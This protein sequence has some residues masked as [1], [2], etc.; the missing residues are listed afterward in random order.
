MPEPFKNLFNPGMIAEMGAHLQRHDA[1][2]DGGRFER[3]ATHGLDALELK[4]RSNHILNA[5]D[6]TLPDDF[7]AAVRLMLTA[8][9][10]EEH[11]DLSEQSMDARGIRG[12]A[13]MPMADYVARHG[14]AD[15][16]FSMDALKQ[17]TKRMSSEFAV[18]PFLA[19]DPERAMPHVRDWATDENYHVRRL[20]SE[21]TR[22]RLPWG[23]RLNHLVKDPTPLLPVLETL[24]DDPEDYV[25]R[26]VA[27]HL[28]DIAK[29]HPDLVSATARDWLA[30]G[31][32]ERRRKLVRH[33]CRTLIK[34]GHAPTL[35]AF[36]F[37]RPRVKLA[38]F[39]LSRR[40]VRFG[41]D[42]LI[43]VALLSET[44]VAQDLL[45]DYVVHHRKANGTTSPKVFKWTT[46]RLPGRAGS[47]LEKRHMF[48][49]VTTRTYHNGTHAI[50][51]QI[52]GCSLGR[53][54][55]EL[56]M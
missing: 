15:F 50:E 38:S 46:L 20:A 21:G 27:N 56:V 12:W 4:Q 43:R 42:M 30:D 41:Q 25:C 17:M 16:D 35:K 54:E 51:I 9:H 47:A 31:P 11:A 29:D 22:P 10:P 34:Q 1:R 49:P 13:V 37:G 18:R 28:N 39:E 2:F 40:K 36:G 33:A 6:E 45:V 26:S 32:P 14:L 8:L 44:D 53:V 7:A 23:M 5:L 48:R 19:H 24:R 52:N 55:F 3:L